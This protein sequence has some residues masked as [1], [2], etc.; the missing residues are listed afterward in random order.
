MD[1]AFLSAAVRYWTSVFPLACREIGAWRRRAQTIPDPVL[2][3][4][5]ENALRAERGNLEG[6]AAMATFVPRAQQSAVVRAMVAFQA[7]YDY[8]DA[9]SEQPWQSNRS[10]STT[11]L[12]SCLAVAV[13]QRLAHRDY[14]AYGPYR[15]DGG[16]LRSLVDHCRGEL[17]RLPRIAVA[18]AALCR[19][20]M[21]IES[22]QRANHDRGK[23]DGSDPWITT[24]ASERFQLTRWEMAAAAGSSLTVFALIALVSCPGADSIR[25]SAVERAYFPWVGALHVLLDSLLDRQEDLD[26][27]QPSLIDNYRSEN[28]VAARLEMLALRAAQHVG[29]LEE[30]HHG[31][32]LSAMGGFYLSSIRESDSLSRVA[33]SKV[34]RA[35]GDSAKPA[36]VVIHAKRQISR[37][38]SSASIATSS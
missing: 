34:L 23:T 5:A 37:L 6:A 2:R 38:L 28:E 15:E 25:V 1:R 19:A 4:L 30:K 16:Y 9:V 17:I 14:Y 24:E 11:R 8:V 3:A 29:L 10:D 20:V 33:R 12:H 35:L 18:R 22:Y 21:R 7:A 13:D 27:G 26:A 32:I 31:L 36:A